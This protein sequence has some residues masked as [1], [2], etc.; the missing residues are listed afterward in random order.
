MILAES[1]NYVFTKWRDEVPKFP[2]IGGTCRGCTRKVG[3]KPP[4]EGSLVNPES[5]LGYVVLAPGSSS[6]CT[7][8]SRASYEALKRSKNE[9]P[10]IGG[11]SSERCAYNEDNSFRGLVGMNLECG[12]G[13]M[14]VGCVVAP[15]CPELPA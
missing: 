3:A 6:K 2:K 9:E 8:P 10:K 11:R 4:Q 15:V 1:K 7:S 14:V 13:Y 5:A 12:V